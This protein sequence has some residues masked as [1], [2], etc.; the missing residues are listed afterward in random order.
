M[1]PNSRIFLFLSQ[2]Y[3]KVDTIFRISFLLKTESGEKIIA[4]LYEIETGYPIKIK[5]LMN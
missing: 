1:R 4:V 2:I 5:N 3:L